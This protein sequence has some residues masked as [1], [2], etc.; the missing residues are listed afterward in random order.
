MSQVREKIPTNAKDLSFSNEDFS[1]Q[2][3]DGYTLSNCVFEKCDF[4][5]SSF[6]GV[7][8]WDCD[9]KECN[10]SLVN[11]KECTM[12]N[13]T[14]EDS[15]IVGIDF[16]RCNTSLFFSIKATKSFLQYCSFSS[17]NMKRVNFNRSKIVQCRF[18]ETNLSEAQLIGVDFAGSTFHNCDL[19]KANF[20]KAV[21]YVLNPCENKIKKAK[22]SSPEC[23][24]LVKALD[25]DIVE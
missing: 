13:I 21:N 10:F 6:E 18:D 12:Q 25:V 17:L 2:S 20:E 15:K 7:S 9:F 19:S 14:F 23:L 11:L 22:F 3:F 8:L 24:G 1:S 16:S 4:T 5:N